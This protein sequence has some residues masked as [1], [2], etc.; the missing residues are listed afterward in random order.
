VFLAWS[1]GLKAITTRYG[2]M[3]CECMVLRRFRDDK[4]NVELL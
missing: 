4:N 3:V 2:P 1:K